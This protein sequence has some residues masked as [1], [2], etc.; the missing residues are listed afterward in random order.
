MREAR[1]AWAELFDEIYAQPA[2]AS[3]EELAGLA[4]A[5]ASPLTPDEIEQA[6]AAQ[7]NPFP[8]SDPLHLKW[9]PLDARTWRMP[10]NPL[11]DDYLDFLSWSNGP[12]TRCGEREFGFFGT[13]NVR[14]YMLAYEFPAYMPGAVPIG[15]DGGGIFC[16][17][18]LRV[19]SQSVGV[20]IIAVSSGVLTYESARPVAT[21]LREFCESRKSIESLLFED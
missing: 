20:P 6:I 14:Q 21:S 8:A 15:L 16:V 1:I 19:A 3:G 5:V 2:G 11:P 4:E 18:D 17:F 7:R 10:T 9:Q 13:S 12:L